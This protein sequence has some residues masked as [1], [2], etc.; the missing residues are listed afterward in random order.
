M[1]NYGDAGS[2]SSPARKLLI[3]GGYIVYGCIPSIRAIDDDHRRAFTM[4]VI[5]F[6]FLPV[7]YYIQYTRSVVRERERRR[8]RGARAP[9]LCLRIDCRV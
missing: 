8:F 2:K 6:F 7:P 3:I 9:C 4:V 5:Y 1:R